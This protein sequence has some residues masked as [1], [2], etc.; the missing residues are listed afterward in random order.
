MEVSE[1]VRYNRLG[2]CFAFQKFLS[3]S[4]HYMWIYN[5]I[6]ILFLSVWT[7]TRCERFQKPCYLNY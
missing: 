6:L 7:W 2:F 5:L 1:S 4:L 3:D